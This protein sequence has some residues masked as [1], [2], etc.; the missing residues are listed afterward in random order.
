MV[1]LN[2]IEKYRWRK[3]WRNL[4][5]HQS[6]CISLLLTSFFYCLH[7]GKKQKPVIRKDKCKEM[8]DN[9]FQFFL[10]F[11]WLV[12]YN[13]Q[14]YIMLFLR[15]SLHFCH[16]WFYIFRHI[17]MISNWKVVTF[18]GVAIW[19][20]YPLWLNF[21]MVFLFPYW[22]DIGIRKVCY[23]STSSLSIFQNCFWLCLLGP[24]TTIFGYF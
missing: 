5:N 15:E 11:F 20:S 2:K 16:H 24:K 17:Y 8:F 9:F 22:L 14:I 4:S 21:E 23:V 3:N 10:H 7:T 19:S 1:I 18:W 13:P 12:P 6:L